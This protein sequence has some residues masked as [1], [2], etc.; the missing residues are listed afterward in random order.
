MVC[1]VVKFFIDACIGEG[2][3]VYPN[4]QISVCKILH[5]F[6]FADFRWQVHEFKGAL[7]LSNSITGNSYSLIKTS[8]NQNCKKWKGLHW[9]LARTCTSQIY[10]QYSRPL[11]VNQHTFKSHISKFKCWAVIDP[12][13]TCLFSSYMQRKKLSTVKA[14]FSK[15]I[16]EIVRYV[17]TT[18]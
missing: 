13:G 4:I 16:V 17:A 18:Q 11:C 5:S 3:F 14:S 10:L 12:R 6:I 7:K 8:F 15:K 9:H 1:K 2:Q